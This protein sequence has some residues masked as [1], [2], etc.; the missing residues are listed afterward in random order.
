MPRGRKRSTN[1]QRK[2]VLQRSPVSDKPRHALVQNGL[3]SELSFTGAEG[4][5]FV[6]NSSGMNMG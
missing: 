1:G 6:F 5:E 2:V 3:F 4:K